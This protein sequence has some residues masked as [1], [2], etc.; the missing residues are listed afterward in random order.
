MSDVTIYTKPGCPYCAAAKDDLQQ[1]GIR[2][3]E[4][5]VKADGAALRRMLE[6]N[7]SQRRVPTIVEGGKVTVGFHGY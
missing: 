5:N 3:A 6:T 1:R 2:Y 7:G 4:H